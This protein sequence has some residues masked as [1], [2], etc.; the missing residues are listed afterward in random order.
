MEMVS[1]RVHPDQR[2]KESAKGRAMSPEQA[3]HYALT[4]ILQSPRGSGVEP[5]G[6]IDWGPLTPREQEVA[7]LV[8]SGLTNRQIADRLFISERT[9]E[10]HV[11]HI[12]NKLN[13]R[14]R[15][16][17]ATWATQRGLDPGGPTPHR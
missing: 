16:E 14:S 8:A 3:V 12:R 5:A 15:T 6:S 10:G 4:E 7:S 11:E 2:V 17:V 13:V 1:E 9:A